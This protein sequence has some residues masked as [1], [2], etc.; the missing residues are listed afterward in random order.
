MLRPI[1][2]VLLL[3]GPALAAGDAELAAAKAAHAKELAKLRDQLLA[4]IDKVIKQTDDMGGGIDYMIRERCGFAD[5]GVTP[6]LPKL[7][8]LSDKYLDAKK[9]ADTA[10]EAAYAKAIE[11]S[12]AAG[13]M[14]DVTVLKA[15]LKT[16]QTAKEPGAVPPP[17]I[18]VGPEGEADRARESVSRARRIYEA[19]E[20]K[21]KKAVT[22]SFDKREETV[23]KSGD[24]KALDDLK[25]R[26][27]AF[28]EL[29][30]VPATLPMSVKSQLT[31][32]RITLDKAYQA[33]VKEMV[34]LRKDDE[35]DKIEKDREAFQLASAFA[36]GKRTYVA[37]LKPFDVKGEG[38][39]FEKNTAKYMMNG[40]AI[41]NSI[42]MHP[43][44]RGTA[45]AS[46]AIPANISAFRANVGVP[47]H[48]ADQ[49]EPHSELY[50]E[51]RLDGKL[52]WTSEP[53]TKMD[54][55]QTCILKL[56]KA[57]KLH[58][59]VYCPKEHGGAHCVWFAP[60][61]V[62]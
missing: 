22:D 59:R 3:A 4:D 11:A 38:N 62:E 60:I 54:T 2:A 37:T 27:K 6:I 29:D 18:V 32:A 26:R 39:W 42:F 25:A 20:V 13:K 5:L 35:A 36:A 44:Y 50:F 40:R 12:T 48:A 31:T 57:K 41:P 7:Q 34:R 16:F 1:L 46:Y 58:L 30:E 24:K 15:E 14:A 47:K 21:F 49:F 56:D 45:D 43:L 19:E 17:K 55:F 53:V 61:L 51:V 9:A 28:D 33:A 10:L 8:P 52:V 23:R